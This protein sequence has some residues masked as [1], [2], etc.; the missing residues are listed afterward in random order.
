MVGYSTKTVTIWMSA[1]YTIYRAIIFSLHHR[2]EF[3]LK[4]RPQT[5]IPVD[6]FEWAIF[7]APIETFVIRIMRLVT[8]FRSSRGSSSCNSAWNRSFFGKTF[9]DKLVWTKKW[10]FKVSKN[11]I[12]LDHSNRRIMVMECKLLAHELHSCYCCCYNHWTMFYFRL[13]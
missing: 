4:S 2:I 3:G 11:R 6:T 10:F 5:W 13:S 9:F 1:V 12:V 8:D 7:S